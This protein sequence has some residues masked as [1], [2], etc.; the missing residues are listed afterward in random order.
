MRPPRVIGELTDLQSDNDFKGNFEQVVGHVQVPERDKDPFIA[1]HIIEPA[2]QPLNGFEPI[3]ELEDPLGDPY[4]DMRRELK[5]HDAERDADMKKFFH[6]SQS[7]HYASI[8][9]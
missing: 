4:A 2:Y 9:P 3:E 7:S 5:D 6:N 1:F 8:N